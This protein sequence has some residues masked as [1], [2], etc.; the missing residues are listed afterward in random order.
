MRLQASHLM[1]TR[2]IATYRNS[3]ISIHH[4]GHNTNR[5]FVYSLRLIFSVD[6]RVRSKNFFYSPSITCIC[7]VF[8]YRPTWMLNLKSLVQN[9]WWQL[10]TKYGP[11]PGNWQFDNF[12]R[13][14]WAI[15]P[16]LRI[17]CSLRLLSYISEIVCRLY[18][19][20]SRHIML[21]QSC[22]YMALVRFQGVFSVVFVVSDL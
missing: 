7:E 11:T 10:T 17:I 21:P 6:L 14:R 19:D 9:I 2:N 12:M 3:K 1:P 8:I 16:S 13:L 20:I 18:P 5:K 22:L 4:H 15:S